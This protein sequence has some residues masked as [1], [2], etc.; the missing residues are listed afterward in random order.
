MGKV[1][2]GST[3]G[4][5]CVIED[6]SITKKPYTRCKCCCGLEK[7]V[8]TADLKRGK[9]KCCES[10][11][12]TGNPV[13]WL[14][15]RDKY[16]L[17]PLM[18]KLPI[19]RTYGAMHA[20]CYN[21]NEDSYHRYGGRGIEVC[22]EWHDRLNFIEWA[23]SHR[24]EKGLTLERVNVDGNYCPS[25]CKFIPKK[26]QARNRKKFSNNK[27]GFTGVHE[28]DKCFTA[29]WRES[30]RQKTKSFSKLKYGYGQAKDMALNY[31]IKMINE[32]SEVEVPYGEFHGQ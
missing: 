25:N 30:G 27:T 15:I 29:T 13:R 21:K 17:P 18:T 6:Q 9:S 3:Y 20:R 28:Y 16:N 8:Y 2:K 7:L 10:C 12:K 22:C 24:Y 32:I 19:Y 5:W 4:Y 11:S 26:H 31:R 14:H 1:L 23:L